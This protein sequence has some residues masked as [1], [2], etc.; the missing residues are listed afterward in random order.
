MP[1]KEMM[2]AKP[3]IEHETTNWDDVCPNMV[4]HG[5]RMLT[6]YDFQILQREMKNVKTLV[7]SINLSAR[8]SENYKVVTEV[9]VPKMANYYTF[10]RME[11]RTDWV[12]KVVKGMKANNV[13]DD[14]LAQWLIASLGRKYPAAFSNAAEEIGMPVKIESKFTPEEFMSMCLKGNINQTGQCAL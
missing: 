14:T 13:S 6:D 8:V 7:T 11:Q 5:Y 1:L 3:I 10:Q 12:T 4:R 9:D 2:G